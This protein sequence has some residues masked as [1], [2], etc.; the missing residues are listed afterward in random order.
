MVPINTYRSFWQFMAGEVPGINHFFMV[1]EESDLA[2]V[3]RDIDAGAVILFAVIPSSDIE[4]TSGDDYEEI[5]SCFVFLVKK[6]DR[7][8]L[9]HDEFITELHNTQLVI[10]DIK[11]KLIELSVDRE[12]TTPFS[13][14]LHG[15]YINGMHTDPEYNLLG[16]DGWGLSFK[17]KTKGTYNY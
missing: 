6:N 16:C 3:I 15:L 17:L 7:G 12:H 5:D 4:A 8:S 10:A 11:N 13:H 14:I 1:H 9:T 2:S